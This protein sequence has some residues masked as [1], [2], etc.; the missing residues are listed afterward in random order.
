VPFQSF[1]QHLCETQPPAED[2]PRHC[3]IAIRWHWVDLF[4][5]AMYLHQYSVPRPHD[6]PPSKWILRVSTW[7]RPYLSCHGL[8]NRMLQVC[9]KEYASAFRIP[10]TAERGHRTD[11]YRPPTTVANSCTKHHDRGRHHLRLLQ[12]HD[13][14]LA[15]LSRIVSLTRRVVSRC[16]IPTAAGLRYTAQLGAAAV[17]PVTD[18]GGRGS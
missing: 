17:L 6:N 2:Q 15:A 14:I 5:I 9:P 1:A 7:L 11:P 10:T 8:A 4:T 18:K 12:Q 13:I 16:E 3:S